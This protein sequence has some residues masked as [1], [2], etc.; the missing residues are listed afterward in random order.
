M[1]EPTL[2]DFRK[3]CAMLER[4]AHH[5]QYS[6]GGKLAAVDVGGAFLATGAN[7]LISAGDRERV[8]AYLGQLLLELAG[9]A[10][11]PPPPAG[12]AA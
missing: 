10:P 6:A 7:L 8:A 2:A 1:T 12:R 9:D 4:H 11:K 5:I 3:L